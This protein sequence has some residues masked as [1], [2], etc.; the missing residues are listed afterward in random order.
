MEDRALGRTPRYSA[1]GVRLRCGNHLGN[2]EGKGPEA[3]GL[4]RTNRTNGVHQL[5]DAI[6]NLRL[7]LL[8]VWAR[9]VRQAWSYGRSRHR[10][11]CLR[12][13]SRLQRLLVAVVSL[14][15]GGMA[16]ARSHVWNMA[17][18]AA[19]LQHR[20]AT[21]HGNSWQVTRKIEIALP[22]CAQSMS[23]SGQTLPKWLSG[24]CQLSPRKRPNCGHLGMSR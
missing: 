2:G 10:H 6:R 16:L 4:G 13:T 21:C 17:T 23:A 12:S 15:T 11:R 14:W 7:A 22:R 8:R 3:F 19:F 20:S 1:V 18:L 9:P 5:P 24:L